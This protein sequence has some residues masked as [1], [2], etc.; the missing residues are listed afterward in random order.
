MCC[1]AEYDVL[2]GAKRERS[3]KRAEMQLKT[4]KR[5]GGAEDVELGSTNELRQ[6]HSFGSRKFFEIAQVQSLHLRNIICF[7]VSVYLNEP[8]HASDHTK[9]KSKANEGGSRERERKKRRG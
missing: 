4:R 7:A 5:R 9:K 6:L 1:E 3:G 8:R 2:N